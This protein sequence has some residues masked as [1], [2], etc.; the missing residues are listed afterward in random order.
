M[1]EDER[2]GV[3]GTLKR[4]GEGARGAERRS[5]RTPEDR[6]ENTGMDKEGCGEG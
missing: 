1:P 2:E 5:V 6:A 4:G 3:R